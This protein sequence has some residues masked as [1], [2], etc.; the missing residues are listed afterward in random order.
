[1]YM[2]Q[3]PL[4]PVLLFAKPLDPERLA[5]ASIV[6]PPDPPIENGSVAP[7]YRFHGRIGRGGRLI[8]D[9]VPI[10]SESSS[11]VLPNFRPPQPNG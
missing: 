7:P 9:R 8:F 6:P 10:G 1:M 2:L 5:V 4:E 11:Y 3:D